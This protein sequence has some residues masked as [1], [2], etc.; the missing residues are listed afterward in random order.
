[1]NEALTNILKVT[2]TE[3]D[4]IDMSFINRWLDPTH[5][6]YMHSNSGREH[7][8][9]LTYISSLYSNDIIF[10][11]GTNECRSAVCLSKNIQNKVISY[12]IVQVLPKNPILS[13]VDFLL[14]D[15]TTD[16]HILTSPFI[17]IDVD[18]DG[19]YEEKFLNFIKQSKWSGLLLLD[20]IHLNES[21][22]K[23]WQSIETEKYDLTSKGHWSGTGLAVFRK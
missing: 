16:K 13:N 6:G 14:G 20:D 1:M 11:I 15:S 9:L 19:V 18:H 8:R 10:D 3:L 2:N 22:K 4:D 17:F 23:I 12:D 5:T 7:Y 21:M